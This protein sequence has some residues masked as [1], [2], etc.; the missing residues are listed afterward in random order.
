MS[1]PIPDLWPDDIA[2]RDVLAP[3][4]I[5]EFQAKQFTERMHGIITAEVVATDDGDLVTYSFELVTPE[6]GSYRIRLLAVTHRKDWGYPVY[7]S[8][9]IMGAGLDQD[10]FLEQLADRLRSGRTR[11]TIDSLLARIG[12]VR[13]AAAG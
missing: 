9:R 6:L 13:R 5:L 10:E 7:M 12:E 4:E 2:P 1:T 11:A 3:K 8:D